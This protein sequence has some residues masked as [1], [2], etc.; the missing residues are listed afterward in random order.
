MKCVSI[1]E[2]GRRSPLASHERR[3]TAIKRQAAIEEELRLVRLGH[4]QA[5]AH[6]PDHAEVAIETD[7][8]ALASV[9][10][11]ILLARGVAGEEDDGGKKDDAVELHGDA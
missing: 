3:A 8:A 10:R 4:V 11:D 7:L 2:G 6:S 5:A 9:A 1:I